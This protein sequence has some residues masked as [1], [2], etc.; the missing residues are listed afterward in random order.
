MVRGRACR[1]FPG[2][3]IERIIRQIRRGV[4]T[5]TSIVRGPET[6]HQ[7][8]FAGETP[9]LCRYF[10]RCWQCHEHVE[11]M[12]SH[13]P[14]CLSDMRFQVETFSVTAVSRPL[15]AG[16]PQPP[17]NR[18][19]RIARL[20]RRR[21][22]HMP[23]PDRRARPER[24]LLRRLTLFRSPNL[25]PSPRPRPVRSPW[26]G[27]ACC[28]SR[29]PPPNLRSRLTAAAGF[30]H[31]CSRLEACGRRFAIRADSAGAPRSGRGGSGDAPQPRPRGGRTRAADRRHQSVLGAEAHC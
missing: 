27:P 11:A 20:S 21:G 15:V 29:P 4:I 12:D 16:R 24:C 23:R 6:G 26:P 18:G 14:S 17:A 31:A 3:T 28:P 5:E 8:R 9:G 10:G 1:P 2:V 30:D 13:C 19:D 7:W 22:R 25:P